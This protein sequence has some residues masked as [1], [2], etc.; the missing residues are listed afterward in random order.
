VS[1]SLYATGIAVGLK[2]KIAMLRPYLPAWLKDEHTEFA[3]EVISA[4]ALLLTAILW[5]T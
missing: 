4:L 5:L 3:L 1:A 2:G